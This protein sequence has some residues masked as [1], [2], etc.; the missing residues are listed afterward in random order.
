MRVRRRRR[1]RHGLTSGVAALAALAAAGGSARAQDRTGADVVA[2]AVR[3][4]GFPCGR[5][6]AAERDDAASRTD[7]AVWV[8]RCDG[9]TYRV[10]FRG[11]SAPLVE[12]LAGG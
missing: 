4:R 9:A 8:L 11:D 5:A 2:D 7:E 6:L 10:R 12:P 3:D 1:R